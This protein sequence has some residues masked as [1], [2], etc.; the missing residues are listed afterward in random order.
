M[1]PLSV[2][3]LA[4][5]AG[6]CAC[7]TL[8]DLNDPVNTDHPLAPTVDCPLTPATDLQAAE[9]AVTRLITCRGSRPGPEDIDCGPGMRWL[10]PDHRPGDPGPWRIGEDGIRCDAIL[11]GPNAAAAIYFFPLGPRTLPPVPGAPGEPRVLACD[12]GCPLRDGESTVRNPVDAAAL[13]D[14]QIAALS[15]DPAAF[16]TDCWGPAEQRWPPEMWQRTER[17]TFIGERQ[18][19][20]RVHDRDTQQTA[21][22]RFYVGPITTDDVPVFTP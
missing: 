14:R 3:A 17:G 16:Q 22:A 9:A 1:R 15:L 6:L 7:D 20:C 12:L 19:F 8:D 11:G 10:A 13:F 4:L 18:V 2:A 21:L 5:A